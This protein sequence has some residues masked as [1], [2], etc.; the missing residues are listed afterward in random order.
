MQ[1]VI[2]KALEIRD[3]DI[4]FRSSSETVHAI[5]GVNLTLHR[6]ET[7]A[8]ALMLPDGGVLRWTGVVRSLG[9]KAGHPDAPVSLSAALAVTGEGT[10]TGG[11]V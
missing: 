8:L 11:N 9:L 2:P 5:R 1:D 3:L 10:I 4:S 7:V 6:G